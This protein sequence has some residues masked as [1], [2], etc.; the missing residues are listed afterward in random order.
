MAAPIYSKVKAM[1]LAGSVVA[2]LAWALSYFV[3]IEL[4]P[5]VISAAIVIVSFVFG[6]FKIEKQG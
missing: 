4:P 3:Q 6:Y 2:I 1:T 5:E